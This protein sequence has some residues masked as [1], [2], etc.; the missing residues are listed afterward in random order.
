MSMRR[1]SGALLVPA[2]LPGRGFVLPGGG[3]PAP[4][5]RSILHGGCFGSGHGC[6]SGAT[7]VLQDGSPSRFPSP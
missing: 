4:V 2:A 1:T 7:P 3:A 6:V 5:A